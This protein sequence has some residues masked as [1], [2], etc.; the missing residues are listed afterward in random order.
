M[1][2]IVYVYAALIVP[3]ILWTFVY[4]YVALIVLFILWT[5]IALFRQERAYRRGQRFEKGLR[6]E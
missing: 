3:F 2:V 1:L 6:D 5:L 4:V